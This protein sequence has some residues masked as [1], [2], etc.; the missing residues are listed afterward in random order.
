MFD[1]SRRDLYFDWKAN[2][3]IGVGISL[4]VLCGLALITVVGTTP[5]ISMDPRIH[6]DPH[7]QPV[8][9]SAVESARE[10]LAKSPQPPRLAELSV[11]S[12]SLEERVPA[13]QAFVGPP[14]PPE[15]E[16]TPFE[17][18]VADWRYEGFFQSG[19][20]RRGVLR[21][22]RDPDNQELV[23][24]GDQLAGIEILDLTLDS[25][26]VA[27]GEEQAEIPLALGPAFDQ[28]AWVIPAELHESPDTLAATVF[29][30]TLG[31]YLA[32][33]PELDWVQETDNGPSQES[34]HALAEVSGWRITS[35]ETGEGESGVRPA[36]AS[37]LPDPS[38]VPLTEERRLA[39]LGIR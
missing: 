19:T 12:V 11:E 4:C 24:V 34:L 9:T 37:D 39:L 18:E 5:S 32:E 31:A 28:Q 23:K 10:L 6:P 15:S 21:R 29:S 30:Q 13:D 7:H 27:R 38:R 33:K 17:R 14:L 2:W 35:F 8:Q 26:V 3:P 25:L 16:P 20:K 22:M 1:P 36:F